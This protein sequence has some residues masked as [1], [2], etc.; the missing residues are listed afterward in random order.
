MDYKKL[1]CSGKCG[2]E[3][4]SLRLIQRKG[5]IQEISG[6]SVSQTSLHIAVA[7]IMVK[8]AAFDFPLFS[9]TLCILVVQRK[10]VRNALTSRFRS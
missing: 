1:E 6:I 5:K 2:S 3:T 9:I 8:Q 7:K 10:L 4:I